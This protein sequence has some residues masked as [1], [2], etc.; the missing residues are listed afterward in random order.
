M[1]TARVHAAP[2]DDQL[3]SLLAAVYRRYHYDFRRY[4]RASLHRRLDQA[5]SAMGAE[6]L[7]VLQQRVVADPAEFGRLLQY[8]T[9]QVSDLFRDPPYWRAVR[10]HV[11]PFLRTF[12]FPRV[13]VAGC[14]GGEE[15]YS[16]AILLHEEGLLDRTL[17]YATDVNP[18]ALRRAEAGS[19]RLDRLAAFSAAYRAAGGTGTL[20]DYYTAAY[21]GAL[22]DK[23]LRR[24][25]VFSD[26][27]LATDGVF[28]EV[29]MISCRNV[30]IYFDRDL[31]ARALQLF[32]DALCHRGF[33]GLG[34]RE[35]PLRES[36]AAFVEAARDE[37]LF[38][39]A[40]G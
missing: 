6:S 11:V 12:P 3:E 19:Y 39:R 37:R 10:A 18:D 8:L 22:F 13:W 1:T 36:P 29:Q 38:R 9:V 32:R 35:T 20:S 24:A 21:G 5:R 4:A 16:F 23:S 7:P 33:L 2:E 31:Q 14:S 17:I 40:S 34:A 28:A 25:A 26:H 27:S 30:L 15:V